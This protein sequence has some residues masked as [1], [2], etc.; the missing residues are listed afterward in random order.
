MSLNIPTL[1]DPFIPDGTAQKNVILTKQVNNN[2]LLHEY[3]LS[4]LFRQQSG[5]KPSAP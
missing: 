5:F 4:L 2:I 3:D 1:P